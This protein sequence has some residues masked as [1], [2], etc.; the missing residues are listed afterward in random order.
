MG[1]RNLR[2]GMGH[3]LLKQASDLINTLRPRGSRVPSLTKEGLNP[4]RKTGANLPCTLRRRSKSPTPSIRRGLSP[5]HR[6]SLPPAI[7]KTVVHLYKNLVVREIVVFKAPLGFLESSCLVLLLLVLTPRATLSIPIRLPT[8]EL[9]LLGIS[10]VIQKCSIAPHT[11]MQ[12]G[13][14]TI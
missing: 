2:R 9:S 4:M 7:I 8:L 13:H 5:S 1:M 6:I 3:L 11:H 14:A 10:H 12:T